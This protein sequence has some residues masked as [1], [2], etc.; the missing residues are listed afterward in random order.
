MDNLKL[1]TMKPDWFDRITKAILVVVAVLGL[2][3]EKT[4]WF[5]YVLIIVLLLLSFPY[6]TR[7]WHRWKLKSKQKQAL[8]RFGTDFFSYIARAQDF[9]QSTNQYGI[10][11]YLRNISVDSIRLSLHLESF[12]SWVL[13]DVQLRAKNGFKSYD[14]FEDVAREFFHVMESFVLI[15]VN[16]VIRNLKQGQNLATLQASQLSGLKQRYAA[17][18]QFINEYNGFR[19]KLAAFWGQE[20]SWLISIPTEALD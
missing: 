20:V 14:E 6:F 5:P 19:S 15:Y 11:Y 8:A 4:T 13:L 2:I 12:F 17:L 3:Q 10:A 16:D 1:E 7:S 18:T 9:V